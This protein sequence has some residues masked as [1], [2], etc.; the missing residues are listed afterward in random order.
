[1]T[2]ANPSIHVIRIGDSI[3]EVTVTPGEDGTLVVTSQGENWQVVPDV[4]DG[5]PFYVFRVNGARVP[6]AA[7]L[8]G[9]EYSFVIQGSY[10]VAEVLPRLTMGA[11]RSD[12]GGEG[13]TLAIKAPMP[14]IVKDVYVIPGQAVEKGER[15][16]VLEAMKM[17]NEVRSPRAGEVREVAVTPGQRLNKGDV[18]LVVE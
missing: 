11:G 16:L 3:Y 7:E 17:N 5:G 2:M 9:T 10:R 6:V 15:L 14:G 13:G 1:M 8:Q 12:E 4:L 18:M